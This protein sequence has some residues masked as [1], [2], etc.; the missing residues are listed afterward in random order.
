MGLQSDCSVAVVC[1]YYVIKDTR[2]NLLNYLGCNAVCGG[3][4]LRL[5]DKF[6]SV[7]NCLGT[8]MNF[9][10]VEVPPVFRRDRGWFLLASR[11]R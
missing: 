4:K 6:G 1:R 7:N 10:C 2:P 11:W 9:S 5:R 8:Y 3:S